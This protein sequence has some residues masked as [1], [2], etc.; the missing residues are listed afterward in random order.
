ME[1]RPASNVIRIGFYKR[2]DPENVD[3]V[4]GFHASD[5]SPSM[6]AGL[7][8]TGSNEQLQFEG[9]VSAA[10][11]LRDQKQSGSIE[12]YSLNESWSC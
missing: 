12:S 1:P 2:C 11:S 3:V 10:D 5:F 4:V 8:F 9:F 7:F 6:L